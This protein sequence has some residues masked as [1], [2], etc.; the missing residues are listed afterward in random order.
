MF[1]QELIQK[2]KFDDTNVGLYRPPRTSPIQRRGEAAPVVR[3]DAEDYEVGRFQDV[4]SAILWA[5]LSL[6]VEYSIG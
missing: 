4:I 3:W 2:K 6:S 5:S 1:I